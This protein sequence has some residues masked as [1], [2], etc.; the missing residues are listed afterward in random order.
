MSGIC[1][2][3]WSWIERRGYGRR[4]IGNNAAVVCLFLLGSIAIVRVAQVCFSCPFSV[5]YIPMRLTQSAVDDSIAISS[6]V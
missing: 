5:P 3:L 6:P 2:G 1:L 4:F